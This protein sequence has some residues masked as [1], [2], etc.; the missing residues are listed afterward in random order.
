MASL[1]RV[2]QDI[3]VGSAF[4]LRRKLDWVELGDNCELVFG[5]PHVAD[6]W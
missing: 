2:D 4:C 6:L 5:M 3:D 1:S